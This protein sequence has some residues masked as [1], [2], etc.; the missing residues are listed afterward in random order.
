MTIIGLFTTKWPYLYIQRDI[1]H[2]EGA[3]SIFS[4]NLCIFQPVL[5][6]QTFTKIIYGELL[7]SLSELL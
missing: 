3:Q 1:I 5:K 4:T 7:K 2:K 6:S